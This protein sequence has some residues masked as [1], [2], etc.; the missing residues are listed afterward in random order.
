MKK[1]SLLTALLF[2]ALFSLNALAADMPKAG[3][4]APAFSLQ[5]QHGKAISFADFKDKWI[6]LYFYPKDF[7]SGC[8]LQAH[9]FQEDE[10]KYTAK[11][12]VILGVSTDSPESHKEFC[13]KE[14]LSFMLLADTDKK[15]S[16]LYGSTLN[17]GLTVVSA[18]NTFLI[19]PKGI[20]RKTYDDVDPARH[21]E[22]VLADLAVL[23]A[24]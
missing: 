3:T 16:E 23:Q 24:K 11:N 9:N 6:V 21:S 18:R 4:A 1:L 22:E 14:G 5:N 7:T 17:L 8:S 15:V 19:D 20:I 13:A 12:A 2:C 10:A